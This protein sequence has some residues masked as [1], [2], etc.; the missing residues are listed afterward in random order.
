MASRFPGA[1]S[2]TQQGS[3][4]LEKRDS[5]PLV[6]DVGMHNG[7]D[8]RNYLREGC[9]VIAIE[10]NPTLCSAATT[11]FAPY[12]ERGALTILNCAIA[13]R[14]GTMTFWVCDDLSEWSSSDRALAGRNGSKHHSVSVDCLPLRDIVSRFG[15]PNY[16]KIDIEGGDKMC[17]NNLSPEICSPYI[18]AELDFDGGD[19]E[20]IRLRELGYRFFKIICQSSKWSQA[21]KNNAPLLGADPESAF[22]FAFQAARG[23]ARRLL[24]QRKVFRGRQRGESGPWGEATAGRWRSPEYVL[25]AWARIC[26]MQNRPDGAPSWWFDVHAKR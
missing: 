2:D 13:E 15:V 18:S 25:E 16:M 19:A 9:R 4:V 17:L 14:A 26:R 5:V 23:A 10:A 7:G 20:I 11:E 3:S 22:G 12:V 24:G 8:T 6:Y 21:T 1:A